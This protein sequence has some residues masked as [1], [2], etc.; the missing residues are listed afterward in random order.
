MS[1]NPEV[2]VGLSDADIGA[3]E[4]DA[5]NALR[6]FRRSNDPGQ[7]KRAQ[8]AANPLE[9]VNRRRRTETAAA[10]HRWSVVRAITSDPAQLEEYAR[11]TQPSFRS[12][13]AA[14]QSLAMHSD[15]KQGE[16]LTTSD[17]DAEQGYA[18]QGDAKQGK[19]S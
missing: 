5:A 8:V 16:A 12:P 2:V 14:M 6:Q 7:L 9:V 3:L 19:A 10:Q 4:Q 17:D 18:E 11:V 1:T 15:A 13:G